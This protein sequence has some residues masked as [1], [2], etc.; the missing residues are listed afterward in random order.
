M[1]KDIVITYAEDI[2]KECIRVLDK[3]SPL[4]AEKMYPFT[5]PG[6]EQGEK[7]ISGY[8]MIWNMSH[9]LSLCHGKSAAYFLM[10]GLDIGFLDVLHAK[11]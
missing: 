8:D 9:L 1:T 3:L 10:K 6:T 2:H 5:Y 4:D 7:K 11:K